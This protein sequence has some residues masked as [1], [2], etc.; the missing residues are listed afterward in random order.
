MPDTCIVPPVRKKGTS[1]P[2]CAAISHCS[3]RDMRQPSSQLRAAITAAPSELPPPLVPG[4]AFGDSGEGFVRVSYAY[5]LKHLMMA[6]D[7]IEAFLASG[8]AG[9]I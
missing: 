5:S 9:Q 4:N 6:L 2:T 1:A 7:R 3:C 8:K